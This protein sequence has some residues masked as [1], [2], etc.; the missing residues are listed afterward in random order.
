LALGGVSGCIGAQQEK[1]GV[2]TVRVRRLLTLWRFVERFLGGGDRVATTK[3]Y[4]LGNAVKEQ[5]MDDQ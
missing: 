3:R 2:G 4:T 5:R 1:E